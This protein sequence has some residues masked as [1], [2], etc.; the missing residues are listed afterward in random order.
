MTSR[1]KE[2]SVFLVE[3]SLVYELE[4]GT[5][6]KTEIWENFCKGFSF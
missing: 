6:L 5:E 1:L 4:S 3:L 2:V